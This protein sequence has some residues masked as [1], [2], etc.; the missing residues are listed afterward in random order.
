MW[1]FGTLKNKMTG[2]EGCPI[3]T[4]RTGPG[5]CCVYVTTLLHAAQP[6]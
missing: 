2:I 1:D 5:T 4:V 6:F 3:L